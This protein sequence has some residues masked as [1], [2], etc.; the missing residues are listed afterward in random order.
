MSS[1][2]KKEGKTK[3]SDLAK[4]SC[5]NAKEQYKAALATYVQFL[6][7]YSVDYYKRE[8]IV[9]FLNDVSKEILDLIEFE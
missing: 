7:T 8:N 5:N 9:S 4:F 6:I 1:T 2:S 3:A